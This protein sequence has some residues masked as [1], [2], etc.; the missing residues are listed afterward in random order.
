ME[1]KAEEAWQD[2]KEIIPSG[3]QKMT[4]DSGVGWG[5]SDHPTVHY[6]YLLHC[7]ALHCFIEPAAFMAWFCAQMTRFQLTSEREK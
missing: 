5:G 1:Q 4:N 2:H 7:T 6:S 3:S